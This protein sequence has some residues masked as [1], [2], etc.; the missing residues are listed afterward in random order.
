[1]SDSWMIYGATG[2]TGGLIVE[3]AVRLGLTPTIA[4]RNAKKV[5]ELADKHGLPWAAF[6]VD[7]GNAMRRA[8]DEQDALLSVAGPFSATADQV[9]R[10]CIATKTH[11]LDVTGEIAVF[12]Q[13]HALD[14]LA[15]EAGVALI[16]GVGFDVV[17]SDCLAA[18]TASLVEDAQTLKLYIQGLGSAS[19][20]TAKTAVES[21]GKGTLV[22]RGG[23]I[24][25]TPA[26][27]LRDRRDIS[28]GETDFIAVSW[29]D[30]STAYHSTDVPD[31]EVYFPADRQMKTMMGLSRYLG[32]V[33]K[34]SAVQGFLKK[35]IDAM[36]AG[37]G[38]QAREKETSVIFA[39]VT[40]KDGTTARAKLT[41]PNGYSL[42]A[43]SAVRC[44]QGIVKSDDLTGFLT[45]SK[46]FSADFVTG[47]TGCE[48]TSMN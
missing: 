35:Q 10:A 32:P 4:G 41:T 22:R 5:Q 15:K 40:G 18:H 16:P 2:Y 33:M 17:P 11:Y 44:T 3:E 39:E 47:L 1:M 28:A 8:L 7:D 14:A 24:V 21:L 38:E 31:I 25:T 9:M 26:G 34:S 29:G 23:K 37:P 48:L 45:P 43:E 13:A 20:G 27:Q 46:A 19:R 6:S 12:E 30:V 36:P 42:T